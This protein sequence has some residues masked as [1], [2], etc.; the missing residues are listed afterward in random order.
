MIPVQNNCIPP[1]KN[2]IHAILG[3]PPTGS[4]HTNVFTIMKMINMKAIKQKIT[5]TK[6]ANASGAV[7][8][9]T[10]PSIA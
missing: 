6:A 3:Q 1:T 2:R 4:P 5:P 8:N 7:E 9:A 10:I